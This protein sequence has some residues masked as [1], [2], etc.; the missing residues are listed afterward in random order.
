V[1]REANRHGAGAVVGFDVDERHHT[2]VELF[3]RAFE[4]RVHVLGLLDVLAVAAKTLGHDF[5]ASPRRASGTSLIGDRQPSTP[6][7][8]PDRSLKGA[9]APGL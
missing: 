2:V 9:G 6:N 5:A 3:L 7:H 4:G 1:V 8:Y